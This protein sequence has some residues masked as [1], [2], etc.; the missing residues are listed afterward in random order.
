[1][2]PAYSLY[3]HVP[4]CTHRCAYCDFNTYAGL[5]TIIP[6]YTHA[7]CREIELV[8]SST[9]NR[10]EAYTL[11][12]GG[13]TPSL[14]PA[15]DIERI[16]STIQVNFSLPKDCEVSLE[17]NPGTV[18][19]EYLKD[20]HSLGVHR[21]SLGAQSTN[22][23]E[24]QILG[25]QH[26]WN[27]VVQSI[28]WA[29]EA[30]FDNINL[31]LIFGLPGQ[32]LTNWEVT[33]SQAL[34]LQPEHFS[35]Y[36]LT[37][38]KGTPLQKQVEVGTLPE[39]DPDL[40]ADMYELAS[41]HLESTKYTQY[42][43]SNWAKLT[44]D[45]SL[46]PTQNPTFSCY[47]N[48][49]YWHNL[50]YLGFGAGAHGYADSFRTANVLHPA[51]YIQ[52]CLQ[53]YKQVFP[54]SPATSTLI[55]VDHTSEIGETMMMGLRLTREGVSAETFKKRFDLNLED[56]FNHPI[57][58]FS[59]LGLLEWTGDNLRLTPRGR[60]LGNQVFMEFL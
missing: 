45:E 19:L 15:M 56:F 58:R 17:A 43:I 59:E 10:L 42:E 41:E 18:T 40:A 8:A 33:L 38:E 2:P 6:D 4:F 54:C 9:D 32:L 28:D 1:M 20:I 52:Q 23:V 13:G 14:L 47:H 22:T 21:L 36:S 49:Q 5:E 50:P 29:R 44:V 24:L 30:G 27:T 39:I 34:S 48:L 51:T 55:P 25:R 60:L 57:K 35:L 31:D 7:L 16:L 46:S 12:F 3:I 26:S 37:L 53:G 11:Y